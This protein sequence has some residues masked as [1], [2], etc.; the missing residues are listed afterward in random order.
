MR[1]L[2]VTSE[3][4]PFA[5]TGGL[6]DVL[7]AL[8]AAQRALGHE[9]LV[10]HPWYTR[11]HAEPAPFWIGDITIPFDGGTE[12]LGI[13][14]LERAGVNYAFVGH[15]SFRG[16]DY[17]G[18]PDDARRFA[19]L[20]QSVAFVADHLAFF[21]HVIHA[22]DW[23][24]AALPAILRYGPV[25]PAGFRELPSVLSVH[26]AQH[27]GWGDAAAFA[28]WFGWS[29]QINEALAHHGSGN[30]LHA[31]IRAADLVTTVSPTYAKELRTP[32]MA[33]GLEEAFAD[34]GE[35]LLGILNGLDTSLF[36]PQ[37][38]PVIAAPYSAS[39]L[40]GKT[41][42]RSTLDGVFG[43]Q[44]RHPLIGVVTRLADQK[45]IDL[46][47]DA[48]PAILHQ[49]WNV[50]L[51]GAGEPAMEAA[52]Q[53]VFATYPGRVAGFIGYD[54]AL[55]RSVYAGSDVFLIP[56]RFEPCGLTQMIAMRYGSVPVA[57][58]TGG[59]VDTIR[60][61]ET[62]FLFADDSSAALIGALARAR[63]QVGYRVRWQA[64]MRTCMAQSFDWQHAAER[65]IEAYQLL[66]AND[67]P[68][69]PADAA[70]VG[71]SR[72]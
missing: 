31:G 29:P 46:L 20:A 58:A 43:L 1:I 10:V 51:V 39:D 24:A 26:N 33:F 32:A 21:P 23:H 62:G 6:A 63:A 11:L 67:L 53:Q 8:P 68:P 41:T 16:S 72:G 70:P 57:R 56:S 7:G 52:W 71:L 18:L 69:P 15:P 48:L 3:A 66:L 2:H 37:R 5:K 9:V 60:D 55:A 25:L 50:A 64:L 22:H 12:R 54:D 28:G 45:G 30:L 14:T 36:D 27:Q 59:L 4:S 47:L 40:A 49:G 34:L 65:Y 19:I 35:G 13:G 61:N 17:Y 38:D 44:P 42:C